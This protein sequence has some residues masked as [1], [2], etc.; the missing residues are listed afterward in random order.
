MYKVGKMRETNANRFTENQLSKGVC[1]NKYI[2]FAPKLEQVFK[3]QN[4]LRTAISSCMTTMLNLV[5]SGFWCS[6]RLSE[7]VK[8]QSKSFGT[9]KILTLVL[10]RT[11]NVIKLP[12]IFRT[13][14]NQSIHKTNWQFDRII[15]HFSYMVFL[16]NKEKKRHLNLKTCC[17]NLIRVILLWICSK[18]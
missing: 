15:N 8:Q 10:V 3:G 1:A 6:P 2:H 7:K 4:F 11:F 12:Q 9:F 5:S 14:Y 13:R 18:K 17:R 16:A